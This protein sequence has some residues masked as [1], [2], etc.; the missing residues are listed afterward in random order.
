[1]TKEWVT[2]NFCIGFCSDKGLMLDLDSV[3]KGKAER[4]AEG[5][6]KRH[7]LE[8]Y[9]LISARAFHLAKSM[10]KPM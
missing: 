4:I 5:L 8:G 6:M 9:L 10:R 1:M 7:E 2:E 3:T